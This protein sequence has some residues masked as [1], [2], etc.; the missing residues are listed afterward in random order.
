MLVTSSA[1]YSTTFA[2]QARALNMVRDGVKPR[3]RPDP[4]NAGTDGTPYIFNAQALTQ[5]VLNTSVTMIFHKFSQPALERFSIMI[6][7]AA[8]VPLFEMGS[9]GEAVK[10]A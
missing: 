8:A 9:A 6:S 4:M 2:G 3:T 7:A 5:R 1:K 10:R